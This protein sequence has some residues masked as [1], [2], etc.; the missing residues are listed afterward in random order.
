MRR[1]F[2][3]WA[4]AVVAA[5][6][7][8]AV[9]DCQLTTKPL[10]IPIWATLPNEGETWG[11]MPV[12]L[13]VC[14]EDERTDSIIAPSVSWNSVIRYTFT[15]RWFHYPTDDTKL[16]VVASASSRT[17]RNGLLVWERLPLA[18]GATTEEVTVRL[19]R[20][21]FFRFFGLGPDTAL[22]AES[23]YTRLRALAR[24]RLGLNV[25][26][27]L[28]VGVAAWLEWDDVEDVGVP[29]LP[30]ARSLFP[31]VPGMTGSTVASQ[32]LELRY[33]DRRG[34]DYAERGF[35]LDASAGVAEGVAGSPGYLHGAVEARVVWTEVDG[36]S[37]AARASWA[38][39]GSGKA[40]FYLQ[41]ALGGSLVLRG[42]MPDRFIDQ[43]A[44][45]VEL[46]QRLRILRTHIFGVTADWRVDPF[47]VA[48]QVF[49]RFD[50]A[51]ARPRTAGGIGL[52]A[53]VHPNVLGR[54]DVAKGFGEH[55]NVYVELGYPY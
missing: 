6:G 54:I 43:Q 25:A 26:P 50:E 47:I 19:Q 18:V 30:L 21:R 8:P 46:E 23:S 35:R 41:S 36:L 40:P 29:G 38:A 48:G 2:M 44:W 4:L 42:F 13:R 45:T 9:A 1:A 33:D 31:G 17:N 10:P 28:N 34:G 20:D 7:A 32:A 12:F 24:A 39:V 52:R 14:P 3:I 55:W 16:I 49:G 51:V 5:H 37:G 15:L 27:H 22:E 53:F 11:F